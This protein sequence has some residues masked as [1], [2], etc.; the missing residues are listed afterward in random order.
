MSENIILAV[1]AFIIGFGLAWLIRSIT[2]MKNIKAKKSMEGF[3]ESERLMKE[4]LQK[5]NRTILEIK[6]SIESNAQQRIGQLQD[7]IKQ[8]DEDIL[9]LQKDNEQT[10]YMLNTQVP[11]LVEL[12]MKLIEANNTI[13]R[14]K[15]QLGLK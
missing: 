15:S 6:S 11:A 2:L 3:L 9:L 13:S 14:Y 5:E 10:E 4:K 7:V 12:K 8:M 1:A